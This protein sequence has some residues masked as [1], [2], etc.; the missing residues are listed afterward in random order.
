[1]P[2]APLTLPTATDLVAA[3]SR[4]WSRANSKA[5][6]ASLSP[7]VVGSA[8]IPWV[9]PTIN[10]RAVLQRPPLHHLEEPLDPAQEQ[11]SRVAQ[12]DGAGGIEHVRRCEPMVDPRTALGH[13]CAEHVNECSEI[14]IRDPLAFRHRLRIDGWCLAEGVNRRLRGDPHP[15]PG[16][17]GKGLYFGPEGELPFLRPDRAHLGE[18][19]AGD[20]N[21]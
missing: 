5:H 7:M 1:M 6:D 8:Q 12:L 15:D 14:V 4:A 17:E 11:V 18:R 10:G 21:R 2:T 9:R 16:L 20:H 3:V 13:R 19:V